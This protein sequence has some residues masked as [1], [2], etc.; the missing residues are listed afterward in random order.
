GRTYLELEE[1]DTLNLVLNFFELV[2]TNRLTFS[3]IRYYGQGEIFN[4]LRNL[5]ALDPDPEPFQS[6]GPAAF[7]SELNPE[8]QWQYSLSGKAGDWSDIEGATGET[9]DMPR[10]SEMPFDFGKIFFRRAAST[11]VDDPVYSNI[12]DLTLTE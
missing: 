1:G 5:C 12:I 7:V 6:L 8:Y 9:Y 3:M 10:L 4:P 11:P 2:D